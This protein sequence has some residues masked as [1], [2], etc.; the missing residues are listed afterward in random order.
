LDGGSA[1]RKAATYTGQHKH[2]INADIHSLSAIRTH[3][4]SVRASENSSCLRPRGHYDQQKSCPYRDSD[5]DPS[6]VKAVASRTDCATPVHMAEYYLDPNALK[7]A[8][9]A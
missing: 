9:V 4:R 7:S 1:Q 2:R 6:A 8:D 3:D 5:S